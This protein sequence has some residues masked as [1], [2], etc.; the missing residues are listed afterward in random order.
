VRT[1]PAIFVPPLVF[2]T[3]LSLNYALEPPACEQQSR[4]AM[5][6]AAA[7]ALLIALSCVGLAARAWRSVGLT[8]TTDDPGEETRTRFG[9][10][11]GLML[12]VSSAL[13][14]SMLWV[15]Q[16]ILPACVR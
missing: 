3:L 1:W 4:L 13:S 8:F 16:L 9:A 15:V 6:V 2:L 11:I 14:I 7:V 10:V 5:H 12:S